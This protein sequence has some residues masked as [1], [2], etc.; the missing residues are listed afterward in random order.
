MTTPGPYT[1]A[2]DEVGTIR[3]NPIEVMAP[4]P[5]QPQVV[6][7]FYSWLMDADYREKRIDE[8]IATAELFINAEKVLYQQDQ[9]VAAVERL[10]PWL[11]EW[12]VTGTL[13]TDLQGAITGVN[14]TQ[15]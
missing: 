10:L 3:R 11:E 13:V 1:L 12:K 7:R 8:A 5:Q 6:A 15:C 14:C 2:T 4:G 9:L